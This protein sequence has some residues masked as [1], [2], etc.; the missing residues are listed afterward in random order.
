MRDNELDGAWHFDKGLWITWGINGEASLR[1]YLD[2]PQR[3]KD[4][5]SSTITLPGNIVL[6]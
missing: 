4:G 3:Y 1:D 2:T 5:Q 6:A